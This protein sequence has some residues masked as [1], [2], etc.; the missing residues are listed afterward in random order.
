MEQI[1]IT[2]EMAHKC[3]MA[4]VDQHNSIPQDINH[5]SVLIISFRSLYKD[6]C[7]LGFSWLI[8][9]AHRPINKQGVELFPGVTE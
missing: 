3:A 4:L 2:K 6:L 9:T 5:D 1:A 8:G 7:S